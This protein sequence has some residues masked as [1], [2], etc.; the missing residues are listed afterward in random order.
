MNCFM[1]CA[2]IEN[3]EKISIS[4]K[5]NLVISVAWNISRF[6]TAITGIGVDCGNPFEF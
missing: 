3:N 2:T 1:I 6:E 4:L 5:D